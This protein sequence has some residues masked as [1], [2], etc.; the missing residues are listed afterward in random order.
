MHALITHVQEAFQTPFKSAVLI[1]ALLLF[2]ILIAPLLLRRLGLPGI[3]GLILSG[4]VIGPHGLHIIDKNAAVDLFATIGLLY[5]MFIAGLELDL[6]EFRKTRHKSAV[7]GALTFILP[8]VIGFPVCYYLLGYGFYTSLLTAS[9]FSTHTLVAYPIASR[10]G[11]NRHESVAL[12]VGGTIITDTAVLLMLPLIAASAKGGS[13]QEVWLRLAITCP[14]FLGVVVYLVPRFSRWFLKS[15]GSEPYAQYIF[16][17]ST[18]FF[19][20]FMAELSG[21]EP[22][23][24]AFAAGLALNRLI[25]HTSTL[26]NRIEFVGNALFIPIFLISVGMIVDLAVLTKGPQALIVAAVLTV[27]ALVGKWVAAWT[28]GLIF[29]YSH[30]ERNLI[31]GLSSSHAAATL[32][33]ILVGFRLDIIDENILNGTIVLI[34]VTCLAASFA[35]EHYGRR[36]ALDEVRHAPQVPDEEE[37]SILA[38]IANPE[39]MEKLIDLATTLKKPKSPSPIYGLSVVMDDAEARS[40]LAEA[41]KL[42]NKAMVHASASGHTIEIISTIDQNVA[43]GIRRIATEVDATD[44]ILGHS[45]KTNLFQMVFGKTN[46]NIIESSNQAVWV[47]RIAQPIHLHRTIRLFCPA[48]CE[49][50]YGFDQWVEKVARLSGGLGRKVLCYSTQE[51]FDSISKQLQKRKTGAAFDHV[52]FQE[53]ETFSDLAAG[54]ADGDLVIVVSP[55]EG[56]LSHERV[57]EQIGQHLDQYLKHNSF[58]VIHPRVREDMADDNMRQLFI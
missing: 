50:E 25:P 20:A 31:F 13:N 4:L 15:A 22:I 1:F 35:T 56:H 52:R 27:V 45:E 29:K 6:E 11:I 55:R 23:I 16:V 2:I 37:E 8:L 48:F 28:T 43:S 21:L 26:M 44:I 32:A 42:L 34:L 24:G 39:T 3:I 54:F 17:L 9:M 38:P 46:Q 41:R 53:W 58:V 49:L 33:I 19:I 10:L 51:T 47:C 40:K 57:L 12:T 5:I 7:F 36:V 30:A 18:V 14:V